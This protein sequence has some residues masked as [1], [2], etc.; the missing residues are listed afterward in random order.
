MLFDFETRKWE[1]LMELPIGF[2]SWSGDGKY[3]YFDTISASDPAFYRFRMS[4]RKLE[5][6]F[7]LKGFRRALGYAGWIGVAPDGS[8]IVPRDVGTQEIYALDVELP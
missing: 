3:I 8:A 6:L 4:D 7:T 5:R 2:P 1:T